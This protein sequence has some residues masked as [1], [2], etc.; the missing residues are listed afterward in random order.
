MA[1]RYGVG[2]DYPRKHWEKCKAQIDDTGELN[3]SNKPRS[4]RPSLLTPT[5]AAALRKS[6]KTNRLFT[7]RQVSDQLKEIGMDDGSSTV[8]RWFDAEGAQ[9]VAR[10]MKPSLSDVQKRRRIDFICDQVDETAGIFYDMGNAIHLDESWFFLLRNKEKVPIFPGERIPGSPR[11]QHKSHLSKIMVIVANV[12]P[13]PSHNFDGKIGIWRIFVLK[14]AERSS[15]RGEEYE[16]ECTIDA[17]WYKT[18]YIDELLPAIKLK[19]PWLRSKRVIVQRDG[20][21]P[22]TGKNNPE[23]LNSAGMGRGWMV[24]LVT[25]PA[26]SP[27]LNVNDLGFFASLKSRVWGMNASSIDELVETIFKQY[28]EYDGDTLE[29]VWQSLFKVYNQTLREMGDNDSSV[30]HS[31]VRVRQR[32]G[33]LERVVKYDKDAFTKAW[34]YL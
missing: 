14:T 9:K 32:A 8:Q 6:N 19:M 20:A 10:R 33:T 28:D 26:Q 15:K 3:L 7:L 21:S 34:D 25:Q 31:G 5:K 16:F 1:E 29:R 24:E 13:D 30:E 12:R 17:E 27:D 18:W 23:I 2:A 11:V 4:G 22:H